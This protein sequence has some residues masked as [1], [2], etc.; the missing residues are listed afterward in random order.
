MP[1]DGQGSEAQMGRPAPDREINFTF[2]SRLWFSFILLPCSPKLS[3]KSRAKAATR[4]G[5]TYRRRYLVA[6]FVVKKEFPYL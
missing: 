1:Q 6:E 2:E 5:M 4:D 3:Q